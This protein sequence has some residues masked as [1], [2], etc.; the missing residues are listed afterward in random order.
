M[1]LK[2]PASLLLQ[3]AGSCA[4][5]AGKD[6]LFAVGLGFQLRGA[7]A[8]AWRQSQGIGIKAAGLES[9]HLLG[10]H[11]PG[12]KDKPCPRWA[13]WMPEKNGWTSCLT[14]TLSFCAVGRSLTM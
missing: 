14:S 7:E 8:A 2:A 12:S 6:A 13:A 10:I 1:S 11:H 9:S 5:D 4:S 3:K